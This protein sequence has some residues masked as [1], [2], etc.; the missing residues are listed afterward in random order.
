[1]TS[2][3]LAENAQHTTSADGTQIGYT[4]QGDGPALVIVHGSVGTISQWQ[5]AVGEL[6]K[7][8]TVYIYDRR[9]RG[10]SGDQEE[11][12]F[13]A[14]IADLEAM[15]AV[16]GPGARVLAHSYGGLCALQH[17][18]KH[19]INEQLIL[20]EPPLNMER[21]VAGDYLEE[22]RADIESGD[23]AAAMRLALEQMVDLPAEAVDGVA[24]SPPWPQLLQLAPTWTREFE[25]IDGLGF[26]HQKYGNLPGEKVQI[27]LG[28]ETTPMLTRAARLLHEI[29][30]GS[31][32]NEMSG[33][34][35][36][37]HATQPAELAGE[38]VRA[39]G[40]K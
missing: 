10:A 38:V 2:V 11:Y 19:G 20:F 34:D 35:H 7:S 15:L 25:Q 29:I 32:L 39:T 28:S 22:Y 9:G 26:D 17:A 23:R 40:R 8:F 13:S 27:L 18:L 33:L 1:M 16:A 24:Q 31:T 12:S 4:V 5:A 36:F 21:L 3:P 30:P 14:E 6:A 37:S